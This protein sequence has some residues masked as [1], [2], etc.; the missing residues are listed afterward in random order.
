MCWA[1][2]VDRA[3]RVAGGGG[4]ARERGPEGRRSGAGAVG[5]A[6][7]GIP[8]PPVPAVAKNLFGARM[9][10]Q[11]PAQKRTSYLISGF[12]CGFIGIFLRVTPRSSTVGKHVSP[13]SAIFGTN[14]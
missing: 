13:T 10:T 12:V 8:V 7:G 6:G 9:G 1:G 11:T 3:G 14:C 2:G 4:R 5:A